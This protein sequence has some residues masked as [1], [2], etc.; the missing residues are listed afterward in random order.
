MAARAGRERSPRWRSDSF[1]T[2]SKRRPGQKRH[3]ACEDPRDEV[4]WKDWRRVFTMHSSE[5]HARLDGAER[6]APRTTR[7]SPSLPSARCRHDRRAVSE[8][9][10]ARHARAAVRRPQ[11]AIAELVRRFEER[12]AR[13]QRMFA[14]IVAGDADRRRDGRLRAAPE[15]PER[16]WE[17]TPKKG[18]FVAD[19]L[20]KR[21]LPLPWCRHRIPLLVSLVSPLALRA[22]AH[23]RAAS[24]PRPRG[25]AGSATWSHFSFHASLRDVFRIL[26]TRRFRGATSG[27]E[28]SAP[29]SPSRRKWRSALP[30]PLRCRFRV[31][32]RGSVLVSSSGGTTCR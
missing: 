29:R 17:V 30:R 22:P 21:M 28:R 27:S 20:R 13:R 11:G 32:R 3:T 14:A 12:G 25:S 5:V 18:S 24:D 26:P 7:P 23:S 15:R 31:R 4:D 1:V 2:R 16:I 19:F 9:R 6:R 10:G 8:R